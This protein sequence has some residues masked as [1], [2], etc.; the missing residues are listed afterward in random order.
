MDV[1][2]LPVSLLR[3]SLFLFLIAP[4]FVVAQVESEQLE[5]QD[6]TTFPAQV[7]GSESILVL[8]NENEEGAELIDSTINNCCLLYTSP[9]PRDS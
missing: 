6:K 8:E 9:S 1:K 7:E 3:I 4:L 2:W 5:L